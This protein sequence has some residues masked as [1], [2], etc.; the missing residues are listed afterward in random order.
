MGNETSAQ[1]I[2]K[3]V[4][5]KIDVDIPESGILTKEQTAKE[6]KAMAEVVFTKEDLAK[7]RQAKLEKDK[8]L[9][10]VNKTLEKEE[11][12]A[13]N[14]TPEKVKALE[15]QAD[16]ALQAEG[17]RLAKEVAQGDKDIAAKKGKVE[18]LQ[19]TTAKSIQ[20][21]EQIQGIS[22]LHRNSPKKLAASPWSYAIPISLI[23][24]MDSLYPGQWVT[25]LD[26]G[27]AYMYKSLKGQVWVDFSDFTQVKV[28]KGF[29]KRQTVY[30]R[31]YSQ[32][33]TKWFRTL[34]NTIMPKAA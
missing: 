7:L 5:V 12:R 11:A 17:K 6:V 19:V 23:G 9:K 15:K 32:G 3:G 2:D 20:A 4:D 13:A 26:N 22:G 8:A 18:A 1:K 34:L 14:F 21:L 25:C 28:T 16:A 24:S 10:K 30:T 33:L 31:N 29:G 27:K